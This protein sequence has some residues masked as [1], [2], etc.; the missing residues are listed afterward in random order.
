M[1]ILRRA[2]TACAAVALVASAA[3][4]S[5]ESDRVGTEIKKGD[6]KVVDKAADACG[7]IGDKYPGL[8][9]KSFTVGTSPGQHY[10]DFQDEQDPSKIIGLEPDLVAAVGK[11]AG[12][13]AKFQKF[14][15]NGLVPAMT[16]GR[17]DLIASG[18][19]AT[20]ERAQKVNFVTYMRAAEAAVV[21]KGNP[22]GIKSIGDMCGAT[23]AQVLGTVEVKMAEEQD[24]KCK[25]ESKPAMKF[26]NFTNNNQLTTALTTKRADVFLT[27]AG[28]AAYIVKK[29]SGLEKGFDIV[30]DFQ[31]GFGVAKQNQELLNAFNESLTTL[32]ARGE[33]ANIAKQWGFSTEALVKPETVTG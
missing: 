30:S 3:A 21:Q 24:K 20:S 15:F 4:C 19:Y 23:V 25:A 32:H 18:M 10:Y 2:A 27:D 28:V 7:G 26:I 13:T 14:E 33:T 9:G 6:Q 5:S 1:R 31:F 11:C 16:S 29:F 12:F 17:I 8:K 22:K